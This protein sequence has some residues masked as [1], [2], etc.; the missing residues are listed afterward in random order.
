MAQETV[1]AMSSRTRV[2]VMSIT[3]PIVA[4]AILGGFL[5]T[6]HELLAANA[7]LRGQQ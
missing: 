2:I 6:G 4:F 1:G 7:S 3:A 5:G